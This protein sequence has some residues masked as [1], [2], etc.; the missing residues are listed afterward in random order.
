MPQRRTRLLT[1]LGLVVLA[2]VLWGVV[3]VATGDRSSDPTEATGAT[4]VTN[5]SSPATT[6]PASTSGSTPRWNA[7]V[8]AAQ[9]AVQPEVQEA[10]DAGRAAPVIVRLAVTV[11]GSDD[12]R[13][14]QVR[15]ARDRF[16]A[17]LPAGSWTELKEVGTLPY[18]AVSLDGEGFE[19]VRAS[20]LVTMI[21]QD[22]ELLLPTEDVDSTPGVAPASINST[23]TM[24]AVAAWA[25][26]WKGA[27]STV[28]IVDTG[29]QTNH[30]Y[31]MRGTTPKTIA[32]ACFASPCASGSTMTATDAPRTG[33]GNP[34]SG[35]VSGCTHGTHVAGIAVGGTGNSIPSGVAPDA[36]LI[37]INVFSEYLN[38]T[39]LTIGA[40]TS[41][42]NTALDWLYYNR[43]RFPGLTAVNMSLG[44]STKYTAACDVFSTTKS[45]IDQLLAVGVSTVIASGN[46][47][48]SDGVAWPACISTAVTVGAV[49]GV[50]DQATSYSND[51][52]QLDLM[53]P[54]SSIT[55]SIMG[56]QMGTMSGTSMATP[57]VTGA[58]AALRQS[59][60]E[61]TLAR[62]RATGYMVSASA[63]LVPSVRVSTAASVYPGPVASVAT[64]TD[65]GRAT[66]SWTPPSSPGSTPVTGYRVTAVD[67]GASCTTATSSCTISGLTDGSTYTFVVRAQSATGLGAQV[68]T[69][70][71]VIAPAP[72]TTTTT[73]VSS[74]STTSTTTLATIVAPVVVNAYN[75]IT[76]VRL[77]DSRSVGAGASSVDGREIATG[78]LGGGSTRSVPVA[79]RGGVPAS[80]AGAVALNVTVVDPSAPGY[81]TVFPSGAGR[82]NASNINFV[83]GQTVPNM[84]IAKLGADG[85]INV[86]NALGSID[87]IVDVVGWFPSSGGYGGFEPQR[88]AETRS[89]AGLTTI[90]GAVQGVG[91]IAGGRELSVPIVG[92]GG[93]P[94]S[95]VAAVAL[96]V[97]A[98]DAGAAGHLTVFPGG[99]SRPTASN[100]NFVAG[101]TVANMVVAKVGADG[102][103]SIFN[104]S[105]AT[106]VV[107]DVV[108]WFSS[109]SRFNALSP[110]RLVESRA[111][112]TIDGRE[113][114]LGAIGSGAVLSF[115]V[116]GRG[117]VPATGARAVVLNVTVVGPSA[118][119]FLTAFASGGS[120]P[121]VSN[122]NFTPGQVVPNLVVAEI[123]ADGRVA[124]L[125]SAG[126][127]PVVVDVVG[128]FA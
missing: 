119:G 38:G 80:G 68:S 14:A 57:A 106:D 9:V 99:T 54:G 32:E 42:I 101:Q 41:S 120:V 70:P 15:A 27:G 96:N 2:A 16:V 124:L 26:G 55:S 31:L 36:D 52:P 45:Y 24:G 34:C 98:I 100:L 107:V 28:A 1:V 90:D 114:N 121:R 95:G 6:E 17:S 112:P 89:G 11:T 78:R 23:S 35:A 47:G 122:L 97:T 3:A 116:A 62:L 43:G 10:I 128:W 40:S 113:Q 4:S 39:S 50:P 19:A 93:V 92:R 126:W 87:V 37:A 104:S 84:V 102:T 94:A 77:A 118:P 18:L 82:P 22:E 117:G 76:P 21:S 59:A 49:D 29:V 88:F 12:D 115:A 110:A 85:A 66:I 20:G 58:L 74:S 8:P 67:H 33:S 109:T 65:S 72:T 125:N 105:G 46:S 7:P 86:T 83:A 91:A 64:T 71:V 73:T 127:T 53:A 108:G 103:V 60:P 111:L 63:F 13:V 79:G 123:G 69:G 44:G 48:W 5:P 51:G 25:A 81:L 56:S 75:P 30:P 61:Q